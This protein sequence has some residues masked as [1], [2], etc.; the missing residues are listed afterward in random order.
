MYDCIIVGAGPAGA[1]A[2]YHLSKAGHRVLIVE[3]AQLP[4]YKPCGGGVSPQVAEWFDFD[5]SPAISV[6]VCRVR[7]TFNL[8]D[9]VEAELP[10]E[11]ALWM[12]RRDEFDHFIVQQAQKQGATL[13]DAT[14][15]QGVESHEDHWQVH[16]SQGPVQGRFLIAADGARGAMAKW[17][18]FPERKYQLAAALEAEPRLEVPQDPV[19][20]FDLGLL[21]RGYLWNFPK[22]DGYSIG[23]GVFRSGAQRKQDLRTPVADYAAAF[24]VDASTVQHFGHPIFIWD[25]PQTLHTHRAVL[26]G[27]SACV[28]DPFTAEGI[29]PSIFS[30]LKAAEAIAKALQGSDTA[31]AD[32]TQV[33]DREWGEEMRWARRLARLVYQAPSLAYRAGVKRPSSTLTMVK[34]FCGEVSYS[35]VAHRAIHRLS[36]GLLS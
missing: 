4:R 12:V 9:P 27:E 15:A 19:V 2:A 11:K 29:R 20:H 25:G 36:A 5:F 22:A 34:V 7:Y 3:A 16:T 18:G 8:E 17:L 14:K 26:A 1:T 31:L 32:Y 33:M 23:G 35:D 6:K 10:A 28:V 30:G 21:Q 24:D 13:W